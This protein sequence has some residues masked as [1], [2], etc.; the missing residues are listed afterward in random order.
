MHHKEK[1]II[2]DIERVANEL[3]VEKLSR[4]EYLDH[5]KYTHYHIYDN[6][7]GW[8]FYCK[9][10]GISSK[11]IPDV[12]DE[13]Y[14]KRLSKAVEELGRYP[15]DSERKKFGLYVHKSRYPTLQDL[16]GK[17]VELKKVPNLYVTSEPIK[18]TSIPQ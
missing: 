10:V 12:P 18:S 5:G 16:I 14:F 1:E 3:G 9:K 6:G 4:R 13:E 11:K 2:A 17:A 7:R 15:K 8:E